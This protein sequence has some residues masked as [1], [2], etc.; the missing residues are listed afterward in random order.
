MA[1]AAPQ[2]NAS[3]LDLS[4][5]DQVPD[6]DFS[7]YFLAN[8]HQ[9]FQYEANSIKD[10]LEKRQRNGD[11]LKDIRRSLLREIAVIFH[12][13]RQIKQRGVGKTMA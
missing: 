8:L 10:K 3:F 6:N 12:D 7:K 11:I 2:I 4:F 9:I 13:F 5:L 1:H